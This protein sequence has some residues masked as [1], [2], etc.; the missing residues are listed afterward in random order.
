LREKRRQLLLR[1]AAC[2]CWGSSKM[3]DTVLNVSITSNNKLLHG[4]DIRIQE[5]LSFGLVKRIV[6]EMGCKKF[7]AALD[8]ALENLDPP[9]KAPAK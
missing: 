7:K 2:K 9:T 1:N 6:H 4:F 8:K 3:S 5:G